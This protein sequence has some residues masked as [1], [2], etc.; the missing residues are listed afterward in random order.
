MVKATVLST[1]ALAA[2][3]LSAATGLPLTIAEGRDSRS[4]GSVSWGSIDVFCQRGGKGHLAPSSPFCPEEQVCLYAN[5]TYGG[6]PEQNCEVTFQILGPCGRLFLLF[7]R[8]NASGIAA[9]SFRLPSSEY[10]G[11]VFGAWS[12]VATVNV[13]EVV[14]G[15][16]LGFCVTWSLADVNVDGK[17]DVNDAVVM[18]LAYASTLADSRWN[19]NCD[20]ANT[21]G[22][23]DIYDIAALAADYGEECPP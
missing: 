15:D 9:V 10:A 22:I 12:I 16:T 2:L 18:A 14:V 17:V 5:V 8:T 4:D 20:V 1:L 7:G 3:V 6:W 21:Y 23:I 19:Y 13:V 11:G